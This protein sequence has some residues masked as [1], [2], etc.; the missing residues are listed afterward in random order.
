MMIEEE[1]VYGWNKT[2]LYPIHEKKHADMR[3]G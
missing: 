1:R 3:A 2:C